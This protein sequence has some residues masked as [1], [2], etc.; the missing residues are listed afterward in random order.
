MINNLKINQLKILNKLDKITES[1]QQLSNLKNKK[2]NLLTNK[3]IFFNTTFLSNYAKNITTLL[4]LK[5]ITTKKNLF[6]KSIIMFNKSSTQI[7][8]SSVKK[9]SLDLKQTSLINKMTTI[10]I[11]KKRL[12]FNL[13]TKQNILINKKLFT[14]KKTIFNQKDSN[15]LN[16]QNKSINIHNKKKNQLNSINNNKT[17]FV[18]KQKTVLSSLLSRNKKKISEKIFKDENDIIFDD[19]SNFTKANFSNLNNTNQNNT[20]DDFNDFSKY[21][22]FNFVLLKLKN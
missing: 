16:I 19:L 4:P 10:N 20:N 12:I 17:N 9:L 22:I 13:T 14:V 1:K 21:L 5:K 18:K 7:P 6:T 3:N 11:I 2:K 8:K 15:N